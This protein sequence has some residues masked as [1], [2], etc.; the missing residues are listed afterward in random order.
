MLAHPYGLKHQK[1]GG[2]IRLHT[3]H[4][5]HTLKHFV[6]IALSTSVMYIHVGLMLL[7][8]LSREPNNHFNES[9]VQLLGDN[10]L[11]AQLQR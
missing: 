8:V 1:E 9:N 4:K 10:I 11:P 2:H 5:T 3:V 6:L 7:C